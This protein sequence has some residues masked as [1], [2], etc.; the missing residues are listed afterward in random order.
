VA[1]AVGAVAVG[2]RRPVAGGVPDAF[3]DAD[4]DALALALG[5][6]L[7]LALAAPLP[8]GVVTVGD[9]VAEPAVADAEAGAETC[10]ECPPT[11]AR[12]NAVAERASSAVK[13][14]ASTFPLRKTDRFE[15]CAPR[16]IKPPGLV[17]NGHPVS[18]AADNYASHPAAYGMTGRSPAA[19]R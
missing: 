6:G 17:P 12:A 15:A 19:D 13:S 3:E 5:L 1:E 16:A 2:V 14:A 4:R 7:A 11:L 18:V 8:G 10:L 9:G